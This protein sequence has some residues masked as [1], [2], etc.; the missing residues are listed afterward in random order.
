MHLTMTNERQIS[1]DLSMVISASFLF[2]KLV[3]VT[4]NSSC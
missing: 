4:T 2:S 1:I 3:D